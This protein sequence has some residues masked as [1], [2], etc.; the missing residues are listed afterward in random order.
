MSE[1][2]L[3]RPLVTVIILHWKDIDSVMECLSA[4]NKN[5][6]TN[7]NVVLVDNGTNS[8]D[9]DAFFSYSVVKIVSN[10][11]NLG[12]SGGNNSGLRAA[13][14]FGA[15]YFWLL[16]SDV[17]VSEGALTKLV[18]AM[19]CKKELGISAP[20]VA[21]RE[22]GIQYACGIIKPDG[23]KTDYVNMDDILSAKCDDGDIYFVPGAAW[24]IKRSTIEIVG[25]LDE[26]FFAYYEDDDYCIR[27]S[28]LGIQIEVVPE[29]KVYH[30]YSAKKNRRFS[31]PYTA[32]YFTR[33]P[34]LLARKY[35][36][37]LRRIMLW[38]L[39]SALAYS[40]TAGRRDLSEAALAGLWD[41]WIGRSGEYDPV[42]RM[43]F[44]LRGPLVLVSPVLQKILRSL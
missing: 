18:D 36:H 16:N 26:R 34:V 38:P 27:C 40:R 7:Y 10:K 12:Y 20:I 32:Y 31:E 8:L 23:A 15:K 39:A 44:L 13:L 25:L 17:V 1:V 6:Y 29:A 41:G 4:L 30:D 14:C 24:L 35:K 5:T 33:N 3:Q 43:P 37:P 19:E 22:G 42:R 11:H 28:K 2:G 9:I 21:F